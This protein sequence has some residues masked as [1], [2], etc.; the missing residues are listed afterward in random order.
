MELLL[1][2]SPLIALYLGLIILG[3]VKKKNRCLLAISIAW[4]SMPAALFMLYSF[5][6]FIAFVG[7]EET[8]PIMEVLTCIGYFL[9]IA[10]GIIQYIISIRRNRTN[11][12]VLTGTIAW[13]VLPWMVVGY[14]FLYTWIFGGDPYI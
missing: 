8:A 7:V 4:T 14:V 6:S 13:A 3:I 5:Q 2:W 12:A 11:N 1:G 9:P 10:A